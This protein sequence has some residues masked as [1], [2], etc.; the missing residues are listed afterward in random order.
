[1]GVRDFL[2]SLFGAKTAA[3][4]AVAADEAPDDTARSQV[5]AETYAKRDAY[6]ATV[7]AVEP[8]VI[9]FLINPQFMGEPAWPG[10]RQAYRVI[11][12]PRS[13]ILAS[14]GLS[15]P[16]DD[17]DGMGNGFEM[18]LFIETPDIPAEFTGAEGNVAAFGGS[19]AFVILKHVCA[20][21]ADA[22]G[23]RQ[24][25]DKLLVLSM[26]FPGV[27]SES[28]LV[29]QLPPQFISDD[30]CI[31]ILIGAPV[32]GFPAL[33]ADM[34]LSPVA[35]VPIV[36]ITATEL[37]EIRRDGAAGRAA[38]VARRIEAGTG[39]VTHLRR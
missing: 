10:I 34:P 33:I 19:W 15:D 27:R 18:E 35:M 37:D 13:I 31:G 29:A 9:A 1:M 26:E 6:W 7:G 12:K 30:D 8:Y 22:G 11:R 14:D 24:T 21:I 25:L 4:T 39:H 5:A 38:V 3:E 20:Q 36:L 2:R 17:A 28:A 32:P 23:I 16:F